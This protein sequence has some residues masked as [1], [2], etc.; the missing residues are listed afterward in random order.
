[1][2]AMTKSGR[3]SRIGSFTGRYWKVCAALLLLA[4]HSLAYGFDSGEAGFT[5]V[6]SGLQVPY[7]VMAVTA[8]P[9]EELVIKV[10]KAT[11]ATAAMGTLVK[12][13]ETRYR[14]T[15]PQRS[16]LVTLE[17]TRAIEQQ[18]MTL[19]IFVLRPTADIRDDKLD[20]Y[21]IGQ[22]PQQAYRGLAAY[23][24]P[25]GLVEV[26]SAVMDTPLSPHFTLR[27]FLCKQA[28][29]NG[30]EFMLFRPELLLK[31]ETILRKINERGVTADTLFIMSGYRTPHY[32]AS[33]GNSKNSRHIYGGAA[34]WYVDMS[35]K[36]GRMDD[37]N[38]DGKID[39]KDA[40]YLYSLVEGLSKESEWFKG[41]IG[42]YG[43]TA[44]HGPFVHVDVRGQR[45]RWGRR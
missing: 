16:G 22:Y 1:M 28:A 18:R 13:S 7:K 20:G 10:P 14:W 35:P 43:S 39:R 42:E 34:D 17:L 23:E 12:D 24:A 25:S 15:A 3:L 45:A 29:V 8:M 44:S 38:R 40:G 31:L 30:K 6:V 37:V 21:R 11:A 41:G 5:A 9:G 27:Q 36:D 4:R 32:N 26:T 2:S 33:I 19:N